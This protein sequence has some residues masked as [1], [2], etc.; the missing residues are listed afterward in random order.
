MNKISKEELEK[1]YSESTNAEACMKLQVTEVT[2]L[3][4]VDRAGIPRK[5]KGNRNPKRKKWS[6]V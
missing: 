4:M 3:S 6:I 1:L 5:G 2:L